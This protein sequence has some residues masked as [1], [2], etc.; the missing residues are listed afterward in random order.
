MVA[1][2]EYFQNFSILFLVINTVLYLLRWKNADRAFRIFTLYLV[3]MTM[4]QLI[5]SYVASVLH[6]N[7]LYMFHF[8][9]VLQF[10]ILSIFYANLLRAQR[11]LWVLFAVLGFLA[12]EYV[13][14]PRVFFEYH[15]S[16]VSITQGILVLY[17]I[18]YL[19]RNI[20]GNGKLIYLNT[21]I[22]LYLLTS[23]LVFASGNLVFNVNISLNAI[24]AINSINDIAYF[25]FQLFIFYEWFKNYRLAPH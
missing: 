11:V 22:F 17:G 14:T 5:S 13:R 10:V 19:Y 24:M 7:N 20:S 25:I 4:V 21:G 3:A 15:P 12:F 6:Q 23:V 9:F 2:L 1:V 18:L 8:Y 16:G